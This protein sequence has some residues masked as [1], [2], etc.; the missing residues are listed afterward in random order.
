VLPKLPSPADPAWRSRAR[1]RDELI[2]FLTEPGEEIE[3][4]AWYAAYDHVALCQLWGPMT[5][6]PRA[7]PR[8]SHEL[9]QRWEDL[10]RPELPQAPAGQHDA[11]ADARHNVARWQAMQS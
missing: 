10:G 4:W 2:A 8:F 3:L 7:I 1:I 5:A 6:L 11:L 9:R